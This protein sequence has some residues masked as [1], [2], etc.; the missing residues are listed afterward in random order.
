MKKTF[1]LIFF[2]FYISFAFGQSNIQLDSLKRVLAK[3]PKEVRPFGGDT[4]RVKI[5]C[6][7]GDEYGKQKND[8]TLY[9]RKEALNTSIRT[10]YKKGK[11]KSY[12]LLGNY[13]STQSIKGTENYFKALAIAEELN[14]I[15]EQIKL[16]A[17]IGSDYLSL[18]DFKESYFYFKKHSELCKKH[19]SDEDYALSI[20]NLGILFFDQKKYKEALKYFLECETW[21]K[22][23]G[24]P[25]LINAALINVGKVYVELNIFDEALIRFKKALKIEDGYLDKTAFVHNEIANIY[26]QKKEFNEALNNAKLALENTNASNKTML[27]NVSLTL[28]KVY[29]KLGIEK[30]ALKHYKIF[31]DISLYQDSV[32]NG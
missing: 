8:S 16:T 23:T 1:F 32:K 15:D 26:L 25:K 19:G 20:N 9:Y 4:L 2:L 14:L 27:K 18:S 17:E 11:V 22:K 21:S 28:S 7:I 13:Y 30:E 31:T 24:K 12:I 10:N 6:E 3:L 29:E 5:L